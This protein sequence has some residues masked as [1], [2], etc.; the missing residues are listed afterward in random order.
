M[1]N[2]PIISFN[3]GELS[4]KIDARADIE[5]YPSGCRTLENMIPT[6]YGDAERRPGTEF[7]HEAKYGMW[8]H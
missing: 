2:I 6:I 4:P 5:K 1:S 3:A 8:R 7:I